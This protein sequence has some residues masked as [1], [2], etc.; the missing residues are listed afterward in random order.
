MNAP[1]LR[2]TSVVSARA[3]RI[4]RAAIR[5]L[6]AEVAL[7]PKPGLVSPFDS[8]AHDDMDVSTFL[9]SLFALRGYFPAI[10]QAG[11]EGQPLHV[12]QALGLA[13]EAR[14]LRAT[15]GINTHRGAIF[16]LG[17]L[18]A[19]AGALGARAGAEQ[20]C[21]YVAQNWGASL[22]A[23]APGHATSHGLKAS[24]RYQVR[25][26][27][28]EAAEGFPSLTRLA[29]PRYRRLI[30]GG[31]SPEEAAFETL[32]LLITALDDTNLLHRGGLQGLAFAKEAA[33][34]FLARGGV[35]APG[36]FEHAVQMHHVFVARRLSPGGAADMLAAT[37]FLHAIEVAR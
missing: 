34:D 17:L 33:H 8:G 4:G 1:C 29:L 11:A 27:R 37:L 15:G 25:G 14:M 5:A 9:R 30:A 31:L 28:E 19:A 3:S 35:G 18:C 16:S 22:L 12:I 24:R 13:A 6:Y 10:A 26:A 32:I 23:A 2:E 20:L 36:W 7:Y 21:H